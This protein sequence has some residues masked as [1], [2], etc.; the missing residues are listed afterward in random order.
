MI[1]I[2]IAILLIGFILLVK[3][4]DFFVDGSSG[5]AKIFH[6]P[7]IVI[8]LT[9]VSFGTSLPELAVSLTSAL[10]G[11]NGIAIGNVVGSNIVNLMLVAGATA[12]I[13][14]IPVGKSL[15]NKDFPFSMLIT[16]ALLAVT[17]DT[18]L[19]DT[20]N[21]T[22]SRG[23]GII[24]LVLFTIFMYSTVSYSLANQQEESDED[25]EKIPLW[26]S[27][28]LSAAGLAGVIA[29]GQMVVKSASAIAAKAGMSETLIGLT[30]VAFGTS[31][32]ELVTSL[33]A[34][35]KGENDIAIGNV[36]GSNIF[37]ILFILGLS[38]TISPMKNVDPNI[39]ADAFILIAFSAF[40]WICA[41]PKLQ[42]GRITGLLMLILFAAYNVYIFMR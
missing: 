35:K 27:I 29:G 19:S 16:V 13:S 28:V 23:D 37:N 41:R 20:T 26:K 2:Q 15:L 4:A 36:V 3:G 30:V 40:V 33:I 32:P 31:L 34:A 6:I 39:I 24:L 21:L 11:I 14:P 12:L 8:G 7:S 22:I 38:A 18:F 1:F 17:A 25:S 10:K 42:L 9:I 5:I